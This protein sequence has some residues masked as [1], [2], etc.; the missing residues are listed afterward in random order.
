[1]TIDESDRK[2]LEW[3]LKHKLEDLTLAHTQRLKVE[4]DLAEA[5]REVARLRREKA[6]L[7]HDTKFRE[8]LAKNQDRWVVSLNGQRIVVGKKSTTVTPTCPKCGME[9]G[10]ILEDLCRIMENA[11]PKF[12]DGN[13]TSSDGRCLPVASN[14]TCGKCKETV[15]YRCLA[16]PF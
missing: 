9:L 6:R 15:Q 3:A 11:F 8:L 7:E 5:A 13:F 14:T 12:W 10:E 2:D 16:I 4:A 1:M